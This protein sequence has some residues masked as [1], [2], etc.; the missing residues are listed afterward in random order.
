[1]TVGELFAWLVEKDF[2][3]ETELLMLVPTAEGPMLSEPVF[4]EEELNDATFLMI[5]ERTQFDGESEA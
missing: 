4:V 2:D 3:V 5:R 1:M